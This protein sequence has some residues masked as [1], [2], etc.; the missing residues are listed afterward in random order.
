MNDTTRTI[1]LRTE[2]WLKVVAELKKLRSDV[3]SLK[4]RVKELEAKEAE[5]AHDEWLKNMG[6]DL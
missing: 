6:D 4:K 2:D 3:R 5:R 1:Q